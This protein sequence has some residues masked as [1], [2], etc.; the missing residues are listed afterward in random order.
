MCVGKKQRDKR[1]LAR[2]MSDLL[3]DGDAPIGLTAEEACMLAQLREEACGLS[4]DENDQELRQQCPLQMVVDLETGN[5]ISI[6]DVL[7]IYRECMEERVSAF[8]SR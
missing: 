3:V 7:S 4:S 8:E 2:A 1:L 5:S 6:D